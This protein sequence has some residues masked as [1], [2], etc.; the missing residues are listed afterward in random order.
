MESK[1]PPIPGHAEENTTQRMVKW[2]S[3]DQVRSKPFTQSRPQVGERR[4]EQGGDRCSGIL[5]T[6]PW[7]PALGA[8]V[9]AALGSAD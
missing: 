4:T 1:P 2:P 5:H 6:L 9:H 8:R 7:R 3:C